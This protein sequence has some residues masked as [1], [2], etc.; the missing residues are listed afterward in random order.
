MKICLIGN[1]GIKHNLKDGQTTKF[2]LYKK[3]IEDEGCEV[4]MVD[5][6]NFFYHPISTFI[7]ITKT[8]KKSDRIVLISGH[9]ACR[10]LIPYINR[11]NKKY[12][13]P[14]IFPV[15]GSGLLHCSLD[16]HDEQKVYNFLVNRDY[17]LAKKSNRIRK[18]LS[19]IDYILLETDLYKEIY[20]SFYKLNNCEVVNNFREATPIEVITKNTGSLKMVYLSRVMSIKG[21]FD[22]LDS[23]SSIQEDYYLDIYG[24]KYLSEEEETRFNSLL[25]KNIVY[26]G[27]IDSVDIIKTL[28]RYDLFVFPTRYV[29]EGTPGVIS[30]SLIAGTPILSSSFPQA[31]Y[32][33]EKDYDSIQ[34]EMFDKNDLKM[35]LE[36]SLNHKD[37]IRNMRKNVINN[38]KPFTYEYNR[39]KFLKYIC[40]KTIV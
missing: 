12:H 5:L 17:S 20:H 13:K 40:G 31:P 14:F 34:F 24:P 35:K 22:L 10:L 25:T 3:K 28:S 6:E 32:L 38:S 36:W 7:K 1:S 16:H 18:E 21:I 27:K 30:E 33:L 23:L 2:R 26:K 29:Y 37:E 15:V 4:L 19:K 8:I 9:R 11:I 39:G